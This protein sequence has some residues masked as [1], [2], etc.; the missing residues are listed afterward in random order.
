MFT[1]D[2]FITPHAVRQF[3]NRIAPGLTYEQALGAIIRGM[4]D[5]EDFHVTVNG[6]ARYTRIDGPWQ[7]RAV[8]REGAVGDKQAVITILRSGKRRRRQAGS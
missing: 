1:G 6:R 2:F 8:V 4:R 3:Q 5:A 7:F